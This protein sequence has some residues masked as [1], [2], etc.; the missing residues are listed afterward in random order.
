MKHTRFALQT[1]S[2]LPSPA[3]V[4]QVTHPPV[5]TAAAAAI[6]TLQKEPMLPKLSDTQSKYHNVID[7]EPK[8]FVGHMFPR[9][10]ALFHQAAE[11][12]LQYATK[13][14]PAQ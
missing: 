9:K 11:E 13:G 8:Y 10:G 12:L 6:T 5:P 3:A 7:K 2:W 1:K 14:C 4:R